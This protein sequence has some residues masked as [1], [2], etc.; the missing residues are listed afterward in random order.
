MQAALTPWRRAAFAPDRIRGVTLVELV[1]VIVLVGIIGTTLG[2]FIV[3]AIKSYEAQSRR[4]ALVDAT[5]SA[6]RRMGRDIR[7]ALPNSLRRS[8]TATGFALELIPTAD[9]GRYCSAGVAN[10][11]GGARLTIGATDFAFEILGCFRNSTF[12]ATLGSPTSAFRLVVNNTGIGV[13]TA[14]STSAV[15]TPST[16]TLT[17][18]VPGGGSCGANSGP[19][20]S[21]R[22]NLALSAAQTFPAASSRQ[23]VFVLED[24]AVPVSYICDA[25]ASNPAAGTLK[26]YVGYRN[27]S[28]YSS[29]IQPTDPL[30]APLN[31]ATGIATMAQNVSSCSFETS[32]SDVKSKGLATFSL[33]LSSEGDT[34]KLVYQVQLDNSQ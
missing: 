25:N 31:T 29:A 21:F 22:H 7:I 23:R 15:L 10:C 19:N 12:T 17:L 24:A 5:E 13:Y 14:T 4:A 18:S 1:V 16:T 8:T 30:A 33:E 3:P 26:R 28:A 32:T 2:G 9:G 27:G 34:V 6:L 20:S 11:A